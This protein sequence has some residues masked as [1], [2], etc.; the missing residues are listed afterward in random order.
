MMMM[1]RRSRVHLGVAIFFKDLIIIFL[2]SCSTQLEVNAALVIRKKKLI[3]NV[4]GEIQQ[5]Q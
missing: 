3:S 5:N 1:R 4:C 2:V